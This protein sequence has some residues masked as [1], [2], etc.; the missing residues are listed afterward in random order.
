MG[1]DGWMRFSNGNSD[2]LS[3]DDFFVATESQPMRVFW[4]IISGKG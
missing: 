3:V 4:P 2:G 1:D